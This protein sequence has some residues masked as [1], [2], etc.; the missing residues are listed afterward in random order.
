M[1]NGLRALMDVYEVSCRARAPMRVLLV[2][3]GLVG[4]LQACLDHLRAVRR[5]QIKYVK[6]APHSAGP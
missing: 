2:G 6:Y 4:L 1:S 5:M 3:I